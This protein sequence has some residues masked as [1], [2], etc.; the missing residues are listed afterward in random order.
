MTTTFESYDGTR[1]AYRTLG[2]G[3]LLV[4][5]P[6]GPGR[7][8]VYLENLAGLDETNTLVLLDSRGTGESALPSDESSY[9]AESLARDVEA[10]R[11][12]LGLERLRLLGH[13]AGGKVAQVWAATN[14]DRVECLILVTTYLEVTPELAE[15][16][17]AARAAR[18][19]EPWFADANDAAEGMAYARGAELGRLERLAR[20]FAYGAWTARE[21]EHATSADHQMSPR[22]S[23]R[24]S[25]V[26]PLAELRAGLATVTA[27][28][29]VIAG[30]RDGMTPPLASQQVASC[31]ANGEL[32]ELAGA[33]HFPWVDQPAA[34]RAAIELFLAH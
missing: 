10:L 34:F 29:L 6:G 31:F 4:C 1:L 7:N 24:F 3:P 12:H 2:T 8:S 30:E 15:A 20:P 28:V 18:A 27:P 23:S 5:L 17:T 21:R 9:G 16:R 32:V 33:G 13:S 14:P 11:E 25:T 26:T 19:G 22:A